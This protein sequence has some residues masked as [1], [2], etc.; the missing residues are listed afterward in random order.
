MTRDRA[1]RIHFR[2]VRY[3]NNAGLDVPI[4]RA[5][6][7]LL[8]L[9]SIKFKITGV[10]SQVTCKMCKRCIEKRSHLVR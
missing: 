10:A 7:M 2:D 9:S 5:D 4:C 6:G 8:D 3:R 1:E